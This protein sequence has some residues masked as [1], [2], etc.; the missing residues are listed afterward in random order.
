MARAQSEGQSEA[1]RQLFEAVYSKDF[2]AVQASVAAGANV[3]A[4]NRW[5][6]TPMELAID[7]GYFEIGHYLVAVRNFK[8]T[9]TEKK[10]DLTVSSG[11]PYDTVPAERRAPSTPE[12]LSPLGPLLKP[13]DSGGSGFAAPSDAD[14]E[15]S[16]GDQ[17]RPTGAANPF[18]PN[19]PAYGSAAFSVGEAGGAAM[20][21]RAGFAPEN[22]PGPD[23][24]PSMDGEENEDAAT[25]ANAGGSAFSNHVVGIGGKSR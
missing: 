7:K 5:G 20:E 6:M 9:N 22:D 17:R 4:L 12:L 13:A 3:E 16:A 19:A 1:T 24:H 23:S 18:D 25:E 2:A 8:R 14:M 15:T 11:S 10:P 21:S